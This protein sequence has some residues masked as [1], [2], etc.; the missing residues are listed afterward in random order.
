MSRADDGIVYP[1][2]TARQ[3]LIGDTLVLRSIED[4]VRIGDDIAKAVEGKNLAVFAE[5]LVLDA[6]IL[7][8]INALSVTIGNNEGDTSKLQ[9]VVSKNLKDMGPLLNCLDTLLSAARSRL[10]YRLYCSARAYRFATLT[11]T[12]LV[13]SALGAQLPSE[14]G[15]AIFADCRDRISSL[16]L[17]GINERARPAQQFP[18]PGGRGIEWPLAPELVEQLK[19]GKEVEFCLDQVTPTTGGSPFAGLA[20][21]RLTKVRPILAGARTRNGQMHVELIH[22][23]SETIANAKG[24][25]FSFTH[26]R[27]P[28]IFVSRL[29]GKPDDIVI[30]GDLAYDFRRNRKYGLFGPFGWW[31]LKVSDV[32]NDGLDLSG[33][34]GVVLEFYGT[35][36][37]FRGEEPEF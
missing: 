27:V 5:N 11:D 7:T 21:I 15:S 33:L 2:A 35:C 14:L 4:T 19:V 31:K 36:D 26:N 12:N 24:E 3:D 17:E 1:E 30:D 20:N 22:L 9:E 28:T 37:P 8:R 18:P 10:L 34:T 13:T 29:G 25:T 23:G 6:H 16:L 32:Y